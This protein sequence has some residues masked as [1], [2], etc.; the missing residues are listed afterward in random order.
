MN[1][2]HQQLAHEH[3]PQ[4]PDEK[5]GQTAARELVIFHLEVD[6]KHEAGDHPQDAAHRQAQ[7]LRK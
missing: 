4:Q 5:I 1:G 3:R 2:Q 6:V 7:W